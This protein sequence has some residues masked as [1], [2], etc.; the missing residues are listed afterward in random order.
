MFILCLVFSLVLNGRNAPILATFNEPLL[1]LPRILGLRLVGG[2]R[3]CGP[4]WYV[5]TLFVFVLVSPP[6]MAAVRRWRWSAPLLA[7]LCALAYGWLQTVGAECLS[8]FHMGF[9]LLGF[10]AFLM[11]AMFAFHPAKSQWAV[12]LWVAPL[13]LTTWGVSAWAT[14]ALTEYGLRVAPFV[15]LVNIAVAVA[16]L[17]VVSMSFRIEVPAWLTGLTFFIYVTHTFVLHNVGAVLAGAGYW[18]VLIAALGACIA[19]GAVL[20]RLAPKIFSILTGG[21]G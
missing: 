4:L 10:A 19:A 3:S 20:R 5:K 9:S 14:L 16:A 12:H 1:G 8:F 21:R 13:A 6:F 17:H 15:Q 7:I 11:G 18:A 2:P